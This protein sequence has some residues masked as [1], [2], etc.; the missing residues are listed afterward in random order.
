MIFNHGAQLGQ[1]AAGCEHDVNPML[2]TNLLQTG[3]HGMF[4]INPDG[5]PYKPYLGDQFVRGDLQP[6]WT[7]MDLTGDCHVKV[8]SG[9]V[10]MR[11]DLGAGP[12]RATYR[13]EVKL[14]AFSQ[15]VTIDCDVNS[16]QIIVEAVQ[17]PNA[18]P[19]LKKFSVQK[20]QGVR[21]AIHG[22]GALSGVANALSV[23][24]TTVFEEEIRRAVE[25]SVRNLF[26]E[27]LAEL[28]GT[29]PSALVALG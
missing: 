14:M 4:R 24:L 15:D 19:E 11:V 22:L 20:L 8:G 13:G 21:V 9:G 28:G 7:S 25:D 1:F 16:M 18:K 29:I 17:A 3:R 10:E 2:A 5:V 26:S 27:K 12:V 23:V 6:V